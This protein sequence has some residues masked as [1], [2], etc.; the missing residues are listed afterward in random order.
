MQLGE[1]RSLANRIHF[2]SEINMLWSIPYTAIRNCDS[3]SCSILLDA[4][5]KTSLLLPPTSS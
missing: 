2:R 1:C 3:V 4:V 5:H